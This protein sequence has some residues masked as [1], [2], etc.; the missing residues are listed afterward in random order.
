MSQPSGF[1]VHLGVA[2][3]I[4]NDEDNGSGTAVYGRG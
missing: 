3:E 2:F 1:S 4:P